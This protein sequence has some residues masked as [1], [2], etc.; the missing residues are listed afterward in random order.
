MDEWKNSLEYKWAT[1][2]YGKLVAKRSKLSYAKHVLEG[3]EILQ[4]RGVGIDV[5]KA[6]LIHPY[7]QDG[8]IF[9]NPLESTKFSPEAVA[10]AVEYRWVANNSTSK[11]FEETGKVALSE[12]PEI[13]EMLVADKVQN[14]KDFL[15]FN[16]NHINFKLLDAYFKA[17]LEVLKI[18][19]NEYIRYCKLMQSKVKNE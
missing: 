3:A 9:N 13:N 7:Y 12:Y 16:E 8:N 19:D 6:F 17:W 5:I 1:E 4:D 14:R 18:P 11:V 10:L 2:I 15:E